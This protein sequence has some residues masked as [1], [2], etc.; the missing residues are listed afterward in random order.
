MSFSPR[1]TI[2]VKPLPRA[3]RRFVFLSLALFFF[4]AVP[5]FVFY[6][7]G[8]R[9]DFLDPDATITATG[10]LYVSVLSAD[11]EVYLNEEPVLDLRVFRNAI[12]IQNL[13]PGMQRLHVQA[14]GLH[15]WVKE[16]PVYPFIVTEVS[17]FQLPLQP[18]IRPIAEYQT[19]T[20]T[21]V[22]IHTSTT[23]VFFNG[24]SSSVPIIATTTKATTTLERNSE[25]DFIK[26]LFATTSV[27]TS[28]L[29]NRVVG[30]VSDALKITDKNK[31]STTLEVATT[32]KLSGSVR[33]EQSGDDVVVAYVGPM[34]AI[35]YY[36]CVPQ[37]TLASTSERYGAAVMQGIEQLL[38]TSATATISET[39]NTNRVCRTRI[40]IDRQNQEI[41][42]FDFFPGS[43]DLVVLHRR[44]GVFVTEVDDRSWQNT[45]ALYPFP[46]DELVVENG[47]LYGRD[48]VYL[49]EL[50]TELSVTE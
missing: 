39:S 2:N 25:F 45:Q 27:A 24:A 8:Y 17:A 48:G 23:T 21:A 38:A 9:Y 44:D 41:V 32:S 3:Q 13:S 30:E 14:P 6:A 31:A 34:N 19:S 37:A 20:G 50:L 47:R 42:S 46:I 26:S 5:V 33:I 40:T 7:I 15:T 18:Q 10:G 16:L 36:F 28:T 43:T 11:G 29:L 22:Y 12:Y 49:F 35:P 1:S 4:C